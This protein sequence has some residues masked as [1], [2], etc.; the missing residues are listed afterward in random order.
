MDKNEGGIRR[1]FFCVV[2]MRGALC[3]FVRA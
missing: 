2:L 3:R 1:S